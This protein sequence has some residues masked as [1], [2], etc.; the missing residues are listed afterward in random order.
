[1]REQV[2]EV[3]LHDGTRVACLNKIEALILDSHIDGYFQH[4]I[5]VREGDIVFDVGANIGLFGVRV[6]QRG[7]GKVR[8]YGFEPIP[9]TFGVLSENAARFGAGR[10]Q[11]FRFGLSSR[12]GSTSFVYYPGSPAMSTAHPEALAD[13]D[14]LSQGVQGTAQNAPARLWWMRLLPS[15]V[16]KLIARRLRANS[17][18]VECELRTLSEV[19]A[20]QDV[21]RIDLLKIDAEG[22]ELE[23]LRGIADTD[24]RKVGQ[25]VVEVQDVGGRVHA[26][27]ELLREHGF[28]EPVVDKERGFEKLPFFNVYATRS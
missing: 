19:M 17:E 12:R 24:W 1:M 6:L 26:V 2:R 28:R 11:V 14:L 18:R 5:R 16:C 23:I 22:E 25:V 20:E 4:G 7:Q 10:W 13:P 9:A 21:P 27:T 8:V 15:P 3:N